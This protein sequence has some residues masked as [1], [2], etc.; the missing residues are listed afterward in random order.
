MTP[1]QPR[2][3]R[4]HPRRPRPVRRG[5]GGDAGR[6][7]PGGR[8]GRRRG[9][10]RGAQLRRPVQ[11][12]DGPHHRERGHAGARRVPGHRA[13][14]DRR[15]TSAS[16]EQ[17]ADAAYA[18][19][20]G[21]ARSGRTMDAL[22]S[23]YRVG[24]RVA[25]RDLSDAGV[26]AGLPAATVAQFAELV[27]AYIDELSAA[28]AAGHADELATTGAGAAALPGAAHP[29]PA[30]RRLPRR[31]RGLG[32]ARRLGAAAPAHR[33][34]APGP[35]GPWRA[36]PGRPA[37][38]QPT[39]QVPGLE[40]HP[41]LTVLLV[42]A[43]RAGPGGPAARLAAAGGRRAGAAVA[44]GAA[45]YERALRVVGSSWSRRPRRP[46]DTEAHLAGSSS[47]PTRGLRDLRLHVLAPLDELRPAA[48]EK[49]R[50]RSGPGC[51]T[52]DGATRSPPSCSSTRR[53]SATGCSSCA[54]STARGWRTRSG[55]SS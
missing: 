8:A 26:R 42:P 52:T 31:P 14:R 7:A 22:L 46:V 6:P 1:R 50:R 36:R 24:A 29:E 20:R 53:R 51:S 48:A 34:R 11:R 23:A 43:A 44:G 15:R 45:S 38:L 17:V 4:P 41:D 9:A 47:A 39:E 16:F 37:T 12:R 19:G 32:R 10:G 49:L 27:F 40:D 30:P 25:W 35:A 28:S 13:G 21:E 33:R 3:P 18:L 54:T 55:C 2:D 5:R